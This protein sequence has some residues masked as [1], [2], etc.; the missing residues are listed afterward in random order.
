LRKYQAARTPNTAF[1]VHKV[2]LESRRPKAAASVATF[3]D[4]PQYLYRFQSG[5]TDPLG[6]P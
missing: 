3:I 1:A 4:I 2:E 6:L 5:I